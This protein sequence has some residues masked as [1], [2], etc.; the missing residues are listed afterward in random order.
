MGLIGAYEFN[1]GT[2]DAIVPE[3]IALDNGGTF[4]E[5]TAERLRARET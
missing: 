3:T 1:D 5:K 4:A 2:Y